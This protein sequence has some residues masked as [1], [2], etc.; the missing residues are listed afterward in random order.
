MAAMLSVI[1][2]DRRPHLVVVLDDV[3]HDDDDDDRDEEQGRDLAGPAVVVGR[4]PLITHTGHAG[5]RGRDPGPRAR[6]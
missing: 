2:E 6:G 5:G 4:S 1:H 3:E